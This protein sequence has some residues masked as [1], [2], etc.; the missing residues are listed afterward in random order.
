MTLHLTGLR[1]RE[2]Y[3]DIT[4]DLSPLFAHPSVQDLTMSCV[5]IY[6]AYTERILAMPRTP[7][8]RLTLIECNI[9]LEALD[10]LLSLPRAL[11]HLYLGKRSPPSWIII[12]LK[13]LQ[14]RIATTNYRSDRAYP[15]LC[16][17]QNTKRTIYAEQ[18]RPH[19]LQVLL[20]RKDP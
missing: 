7:L 4:T 17:I 3:L 20:A 6:E 13:A 11:E 5:N 12:E 10:N 9:G 1:D 19:S 18:I 8:K 15:A 16:T 2:R 14:A